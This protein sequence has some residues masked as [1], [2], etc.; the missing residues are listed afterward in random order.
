MIHNKVSF[1][2]IKKRKKSVSFLEKLPNNVS[3]LLFDCFC[4]WNFKLLFH[5]Q[6]NGDVLEGWKTRDVM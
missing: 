4:L 6:I 5:P 2:I 3:R 1:D